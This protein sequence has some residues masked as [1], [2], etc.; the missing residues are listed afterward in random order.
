MIGTESL[1]SNTIEFEGKF[2]WNP[3]RTLMLLSFLTA[4]VLNCWPEKEANFYFTNTE[5][6]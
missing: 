4:I 6:M 3:N 5:L 2:T 1:L